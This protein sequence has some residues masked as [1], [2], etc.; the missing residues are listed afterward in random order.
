VNNPSAYAVNHITKK[1]NDNN[2]KPEPK[3]N[4][5]LKLKLK[6]QLKKK[7]KI[8]RENSRAEDGM[9]RSVLLLQDER[10][11]WSVLGGCLYLIES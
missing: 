1:E 7:K 3:L 4:L 11:V 10:R 8:K 2:K 9:P 6:L 5:N